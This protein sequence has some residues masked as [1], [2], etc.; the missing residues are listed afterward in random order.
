MN[1]DNTRRSRDLIPGKP[2]RP[3]PE[4]STPFGGLPGFPGMPSFGKMH[5]TAMR[6]MAEMGEVMDEVMREMMA[7][8]G[9][10]DPRGGGFEGHFEGH[11][12]I[13]PGRDGRPHFRGYSRRFGPNGEFQNGREWDSDAD[14]SGDG[15]GTSIFDRDIS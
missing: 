1:G 15:S 13:G 7:G 12:E 2:S 10:M 3:L 14:D 6:H 9:E 4:P 11:Q 5:E 8:F